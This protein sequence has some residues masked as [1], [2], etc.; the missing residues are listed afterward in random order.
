[1]RYSN[2][3]IAILKDDTTGA[4]DI[5]HLNLY[6]KFKDKGVFGEIIVDNIK[7]ISASSNARNIDEFFERNFIYTKDQE[8][9]KIFVE[10]WKQTMDELDPQTK[11][12]AMYDF[13]LEIES[14]LKERVQDFK[15]F[16]DMRFEFRDRYDKVILIGNCNKCHGVFT[17]NGDLLEYIEAYNSSSKHNVWTNCK[18]CHIGE[19]ILEK[20]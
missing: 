12:L 8:K 5:Y 1:M 16:E 6:N 3:L 11:K 2:Y 14:K 15:T 20:P 18:R 4:T 13:K 7:E 10:S 9:R 19:I 17:G